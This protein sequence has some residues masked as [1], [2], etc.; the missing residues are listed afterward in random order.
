MKASGW[1]LI[2]LHEINGIVKICYISIG[3]KQMECE[4]HWG[5]RRC[6]NDSLNKNVWMTAWIYPETFILKL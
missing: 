3:M 6:V 5:D 2:N 1:E 4:M